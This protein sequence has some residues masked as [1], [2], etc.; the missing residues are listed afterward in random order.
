MSLSRR[1]RSV[2]IWPGFVDALASL[3]MVFVFVLLIFMLAQFFLT[4]TLAG[5]NK[6]LEELNAQVAQ[7]ADT[8]SL[9]RTKN[10]RLRNQ[11]ARLFESLEATLEER[12]A[13]RERAGRLADELAAAEAES[14][15]RQAALE[16]RDATLAERRADLEAL[17]QRLAE[18]DGRRQELEAASARLESALAAQREAVAA[19]R[20]RG[21]DLASRLG[22]QERQTR[23]ARREAEARAARVDRLRGRL[24]EARQALDE[25]EQLTEEARSEVRRLNQQVAALREQI[26]RLSA[27]L[28]ASESKVSEQKV[29][30]KELG[31]RLNLALARRVEELKRYRSEFFGRLREV[32][33]DNPD[34]RIVGDRFLFQSELLFA[35]GSAELGDEGKKRLR[36]LAD[37]LKVIAGKIPGDIDWLLRVDGHTDRRPIHTAEFPSNWELSTAR[38]LSVVKFLKDQGIPPRRL[39][40]AGFGAHHPIA[41]GDSPADLARNRRIEIKLTQP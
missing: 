40:A 20:A 9:E 38:A 30:L 19:A 15:R 21:E 8:L 16:E 33:G 26:A 4:H 28:E 39:A 1:R 7:L 10:Q 23:E 22:E 3:L 37:G 27:A 14:D 13:A 25:Q 31:R 2:N 18:V 24:D 17:R 32:L 5:R 41:E 36:Q 29:K 6:A 11:V 12:D 35:T 34:I